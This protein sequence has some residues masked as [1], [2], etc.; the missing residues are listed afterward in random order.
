[1]MRYTGWQHAFLRENFPSHSNEELARMATQR[2]GV[3]VTPGAMLS[4]GKNHHLRKDPGVRERA[5]SRALGS[6]WDP[7]RDSFL[8]EYVPGHTQSETI[9][10][11]RERFG[12]ALTVGQLKNRKSVLGLRSGTLGGRFE[13]G[14]APSNRGKAWADYMPEDAQDRCRSTQFRKGDL[15]HNTLPVGSE[16][17]TRDGYVEVKVAM[18]PSGRKAH[19]NWVPKARVVWERENGRSVPEGS[20][21]VFLDGDPKNLDPANLAVETRSEHAVIARNHMAYADRGSHDVAVSLARLMHAS[22]EAREVA[23]HGGR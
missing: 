10:A 15:P 2:F 13:R 14:H 21:V 3:E 19:D 6:V 17:V 9:S 11:F 8:E 22:S 16:R 20:M 1:M 5:I 4:Y 12:V 23:R 18:R 7:E